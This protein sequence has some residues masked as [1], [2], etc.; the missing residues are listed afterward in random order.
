TALY[1]KVMRLAPESERDRLVL[2]KGHG[3]AALY[4]VLA[5]VGYIDR[6]DLKTFCSVTGTLLGGHPE[7]RVRGIEANTGSLG[8]GL[9]ISIGLALAAKMRAAKYR[10]FVV[11]GDGELQEGSNWEAAM[12][13]AHFKLDNLV[14]IVDRNRLQLGGFTEE[15]MSLEPLKD[16]WRS[17]GWVVRDIDGHDLEGLV[18]LLSCVPF[19]EGKPSAVIAHTVKGKGVPCAENRVEWHYKVLTRDQYSEVAPVLGLRGLDDE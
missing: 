17:F 13:A 6:K 2:S 10:V 14:L 19:E 16:K 11:T 7:R 8:H 3:C 4:A 1:C 18:E 9:P 12:A 5:E 15:L